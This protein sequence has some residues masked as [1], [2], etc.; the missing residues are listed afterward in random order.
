MLAH[1]VNLMTSSTAIHHSNVKSATHHHQ[2]ADALVFLPRHTA[3]AAAATRGPGILEC[4][5]PAAASAGGEA[6]ASEEVVVSCMGVLSVYR[7]TPGQVGPGPE[8]QRGCMI[9]GSQLFSS[10]RAGWLLQQQQH[11]W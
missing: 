2:T 1:D 9:R 4:P 11:M 3:A 7:M 10:A 5:G 6:G 8:G